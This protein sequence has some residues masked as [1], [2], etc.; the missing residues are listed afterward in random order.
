MALVSFTL[1]MMYKDDP[2]YQE[3]SEY[4]RNS[5]WIIPLGPGRILY[6][7]KPFELAL[8]AN[9]VERAVE[10]WYG[11]G[12]AKDRA[13][14]S[15]E[16]LF[17]P[18]LPTIIRIPIEQV[19]NKSLFSGREISPSWMQSLP[20]EMRYSDRYTSEMAKGIAKITGCDAFKIDHMM[21]SLGASAARDTNAIINSF[22]REEGKTMDWTDWMIVRRFYRD[23]TRGSVSSRDFWAAASQRNGTLRQVERGYKKNI[24]SGSTGAAEAFLSTA[25]PDEKAYALL[26]THWDADYKR[27]HP[28]YRAR[29]MSTVVSKMR[30]EI[31]SSVG[32]RDKDRNQIV[33]TPKQKLAVDNILADISRREIRNALIATEWPGW[34]NKQM[35]PIDPTLEIFSQLNE[36][37]FAEFEARVA[38]ARPYDAETVYGGWSD[39]KQRLL[40]EGSEAYLRDLVVGAG[41][42]P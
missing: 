30:N 28:M 27:L 26:N 37:V 34:A 17:P 15:L 32:L 16:S 22:V 5:G 24:D 4:L 7:P 2:E 29:Q 9:M 11:D 42:K 38:K 21:S 36:D 33:M 40:E 20:P 8:P 25:S 35:L 12:A 19:M 10:A 31:S 3:T 39:L 41:G 14:R 13:I 18:M 1:T 23:N 6:I